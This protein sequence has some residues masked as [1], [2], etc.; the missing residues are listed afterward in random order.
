MGGGGGGYYAPT[1][2]EEYPWLW[3]FLWTVGMLMF[4]LAMFA[5]LIYL[6]V[7]ESEEHQGI[8]PDS[9]PRCCLDPNC[10]DFDPFACWVDFVVVGCGSGGSTAAYLLSNPLL[11]GKQFSVLCL[12]KGQNYND[13]FLVNQAVVNNTPYYLFPGSL[14]KFTKTFSAEAMTELINYVNVMSFGDMVGGSSNHDYCLDVEPSELMADL[15]VIDANSQPGDIQWDYSTLLSV[16]QGYEDYVGPVS[17][18]CTRGT[19]GLLSVANIPYDTP[20]TTGYLLM[21]AIVANLPADS[22]T[23]THVNDYNCF[24][25]SFTEN[26]NNFFRPE[27]GGND[28]YRSSPGLDYL[29]SSIIDSGGFGLDGRDLRV[30]TNAFAQR[31]HTNSAGK[32]DRVEA[33]VNGKERHYYA[34]RQI[35]LGMGAIHSSTF[36][37][38]SGYGD[39]TVLEAAGIPVIK[40]MPDVG[41]NLQMHYGSG[42]LLQSSNAVTSN[43]VTGQG[44]LT[45]LPEK[46]GIEVCASVVNSFES[47][48]CGSCSVIVRF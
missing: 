9:I 43:F 8:N 30:I 14:A 35:V 31:F 40:N 45:V 20:N 10:A 12:E 41:G 27:G 2:A 36:V 37:Q 23:P 25:T 3:Y 18:E 42:V 7:K 24:E 28:F 39:S 16:M 44:L 17:S 29:G 15:Y 5:M 34:R 47:L 21:D 33:V 11:G 13:Q 6:V 26:L 4:L 32:A 1:W 38:R 48:F 22:G 46:N 19:N